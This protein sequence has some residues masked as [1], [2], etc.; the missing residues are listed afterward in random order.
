MLQI[1]TCNLQPANYTLRVFMLVH[2]VLVTRAPRNT[3]ILSV[4]N[5]KEITQLT[6]FPALINTH[7]KARNMMPFRLKPKISVSPVYQN[8]TKYVN[9]LEDGRLAPS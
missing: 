2:N 5:C 6:T 3:F 1:L 7:F 8:D 4:S 9:T